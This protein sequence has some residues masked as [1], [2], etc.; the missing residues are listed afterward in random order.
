M[1]IAYSLFIYSRKMSSA[2]TSLLKD[3]ITPW[4]YYF[5]NVVGVIFDTTKHQSSS[6]WKEIWLSS[7]SIDLKDEE[8]GKCQKGIQKSQNSIQNHVKKLP[9]C[10][11]PGRKELGFVIFTF[12]FHIRSLPTG[13]LTSRGLPTLTEACQ[14][15]NRIWC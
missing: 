13:Q 14:H 1:L 11:A 4:S 10:H 7:I 15:W 8:V 12:S 6:K 2:Y 5:C 9:F 3:Y